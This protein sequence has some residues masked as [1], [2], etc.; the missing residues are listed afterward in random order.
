MAELSLAEFAERF[1]E[2]ESAGENLVASKLAE[3]HRSFDEE[4]FGNLY[5]DAVG[6]K[7]AELLS[8]SSYGKNTRLSEKG[9]ETTY[10]VALEDIC[11]KVPARFLL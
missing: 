5:L 10:R 2:F 4:L 8:F 11:S 9:T 7:C 3:A 6:Y 1:P